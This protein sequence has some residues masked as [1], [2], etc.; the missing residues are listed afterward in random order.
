MFFICLKNVLAV[1]ECHGFWHCF[2][3]VIWLSQRGA[4]RSRGALWPG[5]PAK[6]AVVIHLGQLPGGVTGPSLCLAV[7]D[8]TV[9]AGR[10]FGH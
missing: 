10:Y 8:K 5:T 1:D 9:S 4:Q 6:A 3:V 2:V 7:G